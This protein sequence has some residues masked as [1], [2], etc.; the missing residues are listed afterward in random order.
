MLKKALKKQRFAILIKL[1]LPVG[2][3]VGLRKVGDLDSVASSNLTL[4]TYITDRELDF[5]DILFVLP[6]LK[7]SVVILLN[8][9]TRL[10]LRIDYHQAD[11][12]DKYAHVIYSLFL[13]PM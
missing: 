7:N 12:R 2:V 9:R 3:A 5:N 1:R 4:C 13:E 8:T 11:I 10:F 6:M